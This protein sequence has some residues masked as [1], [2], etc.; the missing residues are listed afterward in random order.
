V[1]IT[2]EKVLTALKAKAKGKEARFGPKSVPTV[3]WPDALKV[4]TPDEG[5]DGKEMPRVAIHS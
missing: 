5:G 4:L 3:E 2:P 1:P